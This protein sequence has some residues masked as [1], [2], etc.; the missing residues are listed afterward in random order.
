[1][2]APQIRIDLQV[3]IPSL[4]HDMACAETDGS[5]SLHPDLTDDSTVAVTWAQVPWHTPG[6]GTVQIVFFMVSSTYN[7]LWRR[8]L[9]ASFLLGRQGR[10]RTF[11]PRPKLAE[12]QPNAK[13]L[14]TLQEFP[15]LV[16]TT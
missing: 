2:R 10:Q 7:M 1:M 12:M 8:T 15:N 11:S 9:S 16:F 5:P 13:S 3:A 14:A 4:P 6:L